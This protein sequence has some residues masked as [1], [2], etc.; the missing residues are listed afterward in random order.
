M[1][2]VT[3]DQTLRDII[4]F[5]DLSFLPDIPAKFGVWIVL[6]VLAIP[7][8]IVIEYALRKME[9]SYQYQGERDV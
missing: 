7:V 9:R 3:V 8:Y 4:W 6:V 5:L 1:T 2:T